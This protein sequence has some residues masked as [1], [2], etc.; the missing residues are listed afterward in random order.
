L[1]RN[2]GPWTL[3]RIVGGTN[4]LRLVSAI[5]RC[6]SCW[7]PGPSARVEG[8]YDRERLVGALARA[9][10]GSCQTTFGAI[11]VDP[12]GDG[13]AF[14][15]PLEVDEIDARLARGQTICVTALSN[16]DPELEAIARAIE[17][18]LDGIGEARFNAYLSP[19]G[20]RTP[21]HTDV[22]ASTSLQ[23]SGRKRWRY[24]PTP[25]TSRPRSQA[26]LDRFGDTQWMNPL[27]SQGPPPPPP[28]PAKLEEVT[29]SAGDLL[30]VPPGAWHEVVTEE[31]GLALNLSVR[32]HPPA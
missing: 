12:L 7:L 32:L 28:D 25:A 31:E 17:R 22:R 29:L 6:E 23:L 24:Q 20:A 1:T 30:C 27:L 10:A 15:E 13:L 4:A 18:E 9:R 3:E 11:T 2:S 8:L 19:A 16:C 14:P 5:S 21:F 26:Q